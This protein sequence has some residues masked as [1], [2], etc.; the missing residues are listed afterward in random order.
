MSKDSKVSNSKSSSNRFENVENP[1][2]LPRTQRIAQ[3]LDS[4]NDRMTEANIAS[5]ELA[6]IGDQNFAEELNSN[7]S[8]DK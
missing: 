5:H 6:S 4:H 1:G 2:E 3:F 7:N 8:V